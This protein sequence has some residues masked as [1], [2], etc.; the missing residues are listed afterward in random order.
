MNEEEA[1][2]CLIRILENKKFSQFFYFDMQA[3][4]TVVMNLI[5][6]YIPDLNSR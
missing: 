4:T 2:A 5:Q 1:Y 3:F 6:L